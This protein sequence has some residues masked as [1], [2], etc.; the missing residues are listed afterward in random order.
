MATRK[1]VAYLLQ[2]TPQ[3]GPFDEY[4]WYYAT[5]AL[6]QRQGDAWE[7][8]N[9]ALQERLLA[10]QETSGTLA[11]S[12]PTNT[13]WGGYGGRVYTTAMNA[14]VPG[15][16][17]PPSAVVRLRRRRQMTGPLHLV[18]QRKEGNEGY[19]GG[20]HSQHTGPQADASSTP[21]PLRVLRR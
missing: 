18:P 16:L 11:G 21:P 14:P 20:L 12:W 19:G 15:S 8:W 7:A 10:S 1:A 13:V 5:L 6:F 9:G 3:G 17:L 4:N 2:E